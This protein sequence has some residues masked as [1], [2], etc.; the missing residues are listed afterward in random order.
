MFFTS[1]AISLMSNRPSFLATFIL[2]SWYF[3]K[4]K[5]FKHIYNNI[6][7]KFQIFCN[8]KRTEF[9][10]ATTIFSSKFLTLC[11]SFIL[12][13]DFPMCHK[14]TPN[15]NAQFFTLKNK[16]DITLL[17]NEVPSIEWNEHNVSLKNFWLIKLSN[18]LWKYWIFSFVSFFPVKYKSS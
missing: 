13:Q 18:I 4:I 2:T 11:N 6:P 10:K 17:K 16:Q 9:N 1:A 7:V 14:S 5:L 15:F 8:Q 12:V 3:Y